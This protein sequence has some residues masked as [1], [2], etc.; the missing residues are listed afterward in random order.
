LKL[1][2]GDR[3]G[4]EKKAGNRVIAKLGK[5]GEECYPTEGTWV[6]PDGNVRMNPV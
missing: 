6:D 3:K 4:R 2:V 1:A 5:G